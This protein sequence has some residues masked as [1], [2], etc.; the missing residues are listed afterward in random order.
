MASAWSGVSIKEYSSYFDTVYISLYKYFG[1]SGGAVLCGDKNVIDKMPH[2]VKIHGGNQFGNWLNAAMAVH[3][4]DG[5]EDRLKQSIKNANEIFAALNQIPGFKVSSLD[6]GTNIYEIQFPAG[7][8]IQKFGEHLANKYF[9]RI[10]R[11]NEKGL[12][13]FFVNDSLL[14]RDVNFIVNAFKDAVKVA[15]S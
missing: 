7:L 12:A 11:P 8:A 10:P 9:I 1:A 5:F 15:G 14:Y 3:R 4:L 6:G 2:L 13:K